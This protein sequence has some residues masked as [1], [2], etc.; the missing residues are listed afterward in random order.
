MDRVT[1]NDSRAA[2]PA[3]GV[4][5]S[6]VWR[7]G[8]SSSARLR[9][10]LLCVQPHQRINL[11]LVDFSV[12]EPTAVVGHSQLG[13]ST[14]AAVCSDPLVVVTDGD[15]AENS[16]VVC[17]G[18]RRY[19]SVHLSTSNCLHVMLNATTARTAEF[20][21]YYEGMQLLYD[22]IRYSIFTCARKLTRW[23]A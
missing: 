3:T 23:P 14:G 15:G 19:S 11:T 8:L 9:P 10:R 2:S 5:S 4:I 13:R 16:T 7:D 21:I 1:S 20:L 18:Q 17:G 22:T 12:D 6:R